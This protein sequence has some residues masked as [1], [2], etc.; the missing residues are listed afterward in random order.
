MS[1]EKAAALLRMAEARSGLSLTMT[2]DEVVVIG[3]PDKPLGFIY[4][5]RQTPKKVRVVFDFPRDVQV[6]RL[7]V[8]IEKL[9]TAELADGEEPPTAVAS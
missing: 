6:N 8:A 9:E 3:P 2:P 5:G 7:H 1:R 4:L